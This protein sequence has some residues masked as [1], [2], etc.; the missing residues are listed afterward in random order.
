MTDETY[1]ELLGEVADYYAAKLA[2]FGANSQGVDWNGEAGQLLRFDQ[3]ARVIGDP[4]TFSINDLGCGYG[5]FLDYLAARHKNIHYTGCDIAGNMIA[6]AKMRFG[7][8]NGVTFVNG[9]RPPEVADYGVTS[10]IFNVRFNRSEAEWRSYIEA[11][12]DLLNETS[13]KGFAF[14]CLTSYSD[15]ERMRHNLYYA[16]PCALFDHCK[17]RYSKNVAILHDYGLYEFTILVRKEL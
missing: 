6:A 7:Q 5:A 9:S 2:Q 14:N 17:R 10:G 16:D 8:R 4:G 15:P 11:T 1:S 13:H 3:L 12:L